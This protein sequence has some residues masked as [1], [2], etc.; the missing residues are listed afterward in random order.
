MMIFALRPMGWNGSFVGI[1]AVVSDCHIHICARPVDV[2]A[3]PNR[4]IPC[5]GIDAARAS[6][7]GSDRLRDVSRDFNHSAAGG[8]RLRAG[9]RGVGETLSQ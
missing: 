7:G 6:R 5:D 4:R 3:A 1:A 9:G 8:L 2:D